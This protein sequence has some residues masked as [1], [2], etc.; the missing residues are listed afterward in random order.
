MDLYKAVDGIV[1]CSSTCGME[2]Y[3]Y[4]LPVFRFTSQFI[5]LKVGENSF[6]PQIIYSIDNIKETDLISHKP[7]QLF[8]YI[9]KN[10][11]L[12]ILN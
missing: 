8:S 2:A 7:I 5:D 12:K 6:T 3:Q 4:G 1:Y 10:V 9:N 11:W